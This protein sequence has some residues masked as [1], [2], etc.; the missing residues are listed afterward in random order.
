MTFR[1][2]GIPSIMKFT[3]E[4]VDLRDA[5][6]VVLLRDGADGLEVF[7]LRRNLDSDFVGGAYVFPGGGVDLDDRTADLD[8]VCVGRGDADASECVGV[9]RGGLAYW[10]AAIRESFEEAGLLL[11]YEDGDSFVDLDADPARWV[12]HRR[13]VDAGERR[14]LEVCEAEGLRLAVDQ[15]HYFARWITPEGP[16]RRYDTY[17]F[18]AAAPPNQTPL[19][20]DREAIANEWLRPADGLHRALAGELTMLPPTIAAL[21]A[22]RGFET[23]DEAIAAV[24][25]V[26]EVPTILPRFIRSETASHFLLPGQPGYDGE[27]IPEGV[28]PAA[29]AVPVTGFGLLTTD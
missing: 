3:D 23:V 7:M 11:A 17:F 6:T 28:D 2:E 13:L 5:A 9:D 19:H 18:L 15:M 8:L 21:E 25:R 24:T 26:R 1:D 4:D 20:D 27:P 14:L 12:D 16:T 10:V 29:T 22:L